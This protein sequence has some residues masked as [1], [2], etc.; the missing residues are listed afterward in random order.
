MRWWREIHD[1]KILIIVPTINLVTQLMSDFV[2]YSNDKFS[3][4]HGI[5]GGKEKQTD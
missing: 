4:M 5:M 3:D 1:R 2:D